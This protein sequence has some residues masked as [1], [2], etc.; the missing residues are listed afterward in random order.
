MEDKRIIELF[1]ERS[2]TAIQETARKYGGYLRYIALRVVGDELDSEEIENDTYLRAWNSIPPEKPS[3]LK[4][5]LASICRNLAINR[6]NL[7][8][9]RK[10]GETE[11][12]LDELAEC[13]ADPSEENDLAE[14]FTLR[15]AIEEFL[16]SLD[17]KTRVI[18][19]QRYFYVCPVA[20]IAERHGMKESTVTM[21]LFRTRKK[22]KEHL[23][24]EGIDL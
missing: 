2:E 9:A 24:K 4:G 15:R 3:S 20:E 17:T 12:A 5:Y 19:L 16:R 11:I 1:W 13:V 6:Y 23:C 10:R 18:F 21:L 8:N 7:K 14:A 22:L